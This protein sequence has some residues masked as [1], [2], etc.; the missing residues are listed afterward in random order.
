MADRNALLDQIQKGRRLKKATTNDRSAPIV[1]AKPSGGGMGA[2][3]MA[4][5]P[6]MGGSGMKTATAPAAA[7]PQAPQLGGLFAGGM[8][9]LKKT[10][11]SAVET[12]R[13]K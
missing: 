6:P 8:P 3:A 11:G 4:R 9:T 2:T 12:G 5:P 7:A 13:S 1:D 10:Q